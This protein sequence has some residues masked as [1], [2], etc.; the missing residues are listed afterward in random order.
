M[1]GLAAGKAF[2]GKGNAASYYRLYVGLEKRRPILSVVDASLGIGLSLIGEP[3]KGEPGTTPSGRS[4]LVSLI[5]ALR[6]DPG[7]MGGGYLSASLGPSAAFGKDK[8]ELGGVVGLGV[9]YRWRVLDVSLN[10]GIDYNP[11]RN[12]GEETMY[13][14][15]ASFSLAQKVRP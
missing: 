15:S 3:E 4:T 12:L 10:A 9:G 2:T 11:T 7:R 14:L 6:F 5:G 1:V 8:P 13:T